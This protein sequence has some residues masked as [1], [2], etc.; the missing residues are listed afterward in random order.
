MWNV[1]AP[2]NICK[3]KTMLLAVYFSANTPHFDFCR[4]QNT[5]AYNVISRNCVFGILPS[6]LEIESYTMISLFHVFVPTGHTDERM[7]QER[8][9]NDD[10]IPHGEITTLHI[11]R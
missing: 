5:A 2:K 4:V 8:V 11:W 1:R 9:N 10:V 3:L 7:L 6:R